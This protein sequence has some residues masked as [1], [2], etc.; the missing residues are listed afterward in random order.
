MDYTGIQALIT[1]TD[2]SNA[3]DDEIIRSMS[4]ETRNYLET[5]RNSASAWAFAISRRCGVGDELSA[6]ELAVFK[7]ALIKRSL[8][9]LYAIHDVE[10]D[11]SDKHDDAQ[12]L[13]VGLFGECARLDQSSDKDT[14]SIVQA[15]MS[16][17]Q[18][19]S[20]RIK[21]IPAYWE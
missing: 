13:M 9:E 1:D 7:I 5:A 2:I 3:A 12:N 4:D 10:I 21:P 11:A 20:R 17:D 14:R 8:Y 6:D 18:K 15:S 19:L 16:Y